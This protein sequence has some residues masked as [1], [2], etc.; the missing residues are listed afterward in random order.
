MMSVNNCIFNTNYFY[1][2]Y[3]LLFLFIKIIN[4]TP[5]TKLVLDD[6]EVKIFRHI[7][8]AP[9]L[10]L[11]WRQGLFLFYFNLDQYVNCCLDRH[12]LDIK[13]CL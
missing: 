2:Y 4:W 8:F 1:Y 5:E 3:F 12:S 7:L 9:S 11:S 6:L 10:I 13:R